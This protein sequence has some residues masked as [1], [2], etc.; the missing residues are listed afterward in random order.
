[1]ENFQT[2][3]ECM[4]RM[5]MMASGDPT[6]DLSD[7][8]LYALNALLAK[9]EKYDILANALK[10]ICDPHNWDGIYMPRIDCQTIAERA[11]LEAAK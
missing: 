4:E 1:M 7:N 6:W 9:A 2:P 10:V 5:R 11:L 3:N 8:D